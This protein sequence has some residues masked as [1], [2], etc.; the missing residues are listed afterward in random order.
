[1]FDGIGRVSGGRFVG[2]SGALASY[3]VAFVAVPLLLSTP[4]A[5]EMGRLSW[6][7]FQLNPLRT[8]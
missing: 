5:P 1:V 3:V 2:D 7:D 6:Y 8:S 4:S